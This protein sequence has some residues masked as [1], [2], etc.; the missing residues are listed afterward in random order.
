[1][2]RGDRSTAKTTRTNQQSS[3]RLDEQ[4]P[5]LWVQGQQGLGVRERRLPQPSSCQMPMSGI[6]VTQV[7]LFIW[8]LFHKS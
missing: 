5:H 8:N 1:M 6:H 2:L 7:S 4:M 3:P